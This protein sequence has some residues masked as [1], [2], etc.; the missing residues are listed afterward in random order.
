[1]K[2][3]EPCSTEELEESEDNLTKVFVSRLSH[4]MIIN[5]N[6]VCCAYSIAELATD[7][8]LNRLLSD[9]PR[10]IRPAVPAGFTSHP[11]SNHLQI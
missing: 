1:M 11:K 9:F 7:L 8:T 5:K 6:L 2:Y 10:Q 3:I 4:C